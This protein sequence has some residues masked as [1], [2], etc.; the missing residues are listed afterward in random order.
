MSVEDEKEEVRIDLEED[1]NGTYFFNSKDLN[2]LEHL[3]ELKKSGVDSFKIEGRNKSVY[4][5]SLVTR[6]YRNVLDALER[7]E[8]KKQFFD[9]VTTVLGSQ[10][11]TEKVSKLF[12]EIPV[13][14]GNGGTTIKKLGEE[15]E[16][17]TS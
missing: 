7:K 17:K 14:D 2:L 13:F 12:S 4:D 9:V 6:A 3:E 5:V 8:S 11:K 10:V 1:L 15:S 16:T